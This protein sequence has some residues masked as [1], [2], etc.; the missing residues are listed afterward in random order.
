[1]TAQLVGFLQIDGYGH[2]GESRRG[3]ETVEVE[4]DNGNKIPL[5]DR[6]LV[7][8]DVCTDHD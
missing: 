2:P 1:M 4:M 3:G 5:L 8:E 6:R 7:I